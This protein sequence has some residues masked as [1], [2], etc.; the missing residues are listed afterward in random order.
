M[1]IDFHYFYS[2]FNYGID[3]KYIQSVDIDG[4]ILGG[5]QALG[6]LYYDVLNRFNR[7]QDRRRSQ[8]HLYK[9]VNHQI[10]EIDFVEFKVNQ[11]DQ[12]LVKELDK[13]YKNE[14]DQ[15]ILLNKLSIKLNRYIEQVEND[16]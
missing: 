7:L 2:F 4:V 12:L 14:Q 13:L 6:N 1:L 3:D 9:D 16:L 5:I 15:T 8:Y 11:L 10:S